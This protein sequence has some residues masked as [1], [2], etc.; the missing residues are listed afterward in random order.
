[1]R[2]Q[3]D[4]LHVETENRIAVV[5]DSTC[6]IPD[7]TIDEHGVI[8]V[9]I[10]LMDGTRTYLDRVDIHGADLYERMRRDSSS[11][12]TSQPAPGAFAE[13]F[14]DALSSS[15]EVL[16]LTVGGRLSGTVNAAKAAARIAGEDAI[17][18][19]DSRST[20]LGLGMLALRAQEMADQ[21]TSVT[22]IVAELNRVR[23]QSG[24]LVAFDTLEHLVR[25]GRIG[26][27]RGWIGTLLDVKPVFELNREGEV[28]PVAKARGREAVRQA[29]LDELDRRLTPRPVRLRLGVVHA[30]AAELAEDIR[31]EVERRFQPY[32]CLVG[33]V[34]AAIGVH[35][36]PGA[37]A[38]FYQIEDGPDPAAGNNPRVDQI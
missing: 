16:C 28:A 31:R 7:S 8:V 3:H 38:V 15:A 13:A 5:V 4:A 34:T 32:E 35:S 17:T 10:Q 24:A 36:G 1:M 14:S 25:S 21:G 20:S 29:I 22:D 2:E 6:D 12:T 23:D 18:V 33:H 37:W 30:D 27:A 9:P 26:R 19:F 11:F